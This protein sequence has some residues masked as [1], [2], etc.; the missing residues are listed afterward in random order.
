MLVS[1]ECAYSSLQGTH[2]QSTAVTHTQS[3]IESHNQST[4]FPHTQSTL[5]PHT[6]G[7]VVTHT[8]STLDPVVPLSSFSADG[9]ALVLLFVDGGSAV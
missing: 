2:T 9:C 6:H 7:T 1:V 4:V 3:T 5:V 8:Q